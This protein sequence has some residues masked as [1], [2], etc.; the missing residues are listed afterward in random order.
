M[1]DWKVSIG[2]NRPSC[3][4]K[5]KFLKA[6]KPQQ[7]WH[8]SS[9]AVGHQGF[10]QRQRSFEYDRFLAGAASDEAWRPHYD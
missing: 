7:T 10:W 4:F 5:D 1:N 2:C 8:R 9:D 6:E 3:E